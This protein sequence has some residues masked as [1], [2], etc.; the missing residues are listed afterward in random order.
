MR[1]RMIRK[2]VATALVWIL[3][4]LAVLV[5]FI[6]AFERSGGFSVDRFYKIF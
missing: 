2:L 1:N 3:A 5:V 4:I 6:L